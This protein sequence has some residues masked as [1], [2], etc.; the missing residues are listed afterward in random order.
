MTAIFINEALNPLDIMFLMDGLVL[1][2]PIPELKN[3]KNA[4]PEKGKIWI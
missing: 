3:G 4:F 1:S 2:L